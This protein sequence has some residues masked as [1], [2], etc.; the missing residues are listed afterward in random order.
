MNKHPTCGSPPRSCYILDRGCNTSVSLIDQ[1]RHLLKTRIDVVR[2]KENHKDNLKL[3]LEDIKSATK[4]FSQDNIIGHGDSGNVYKGATHNT[5][6]DNIIAAK[7]LDK[8][9][10]QGDAEILTEVAAAKFMAELDILME[11]K[12]INV[13]GLVGYCDEEDENVVVY[14]YASR[15][16]LDKYLSDDSLTWVMRLKICI[17]IALGLE[18][19][20][21]SVSSSGQ[22]GN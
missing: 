9:S 21:G 13:I 8:K 6:G 19:L 5:Q 20:H 14:E 16:S 15:G 12:H 11:Y 17:D 4:D 22:T 2:S 7:R 18:F 10:G 1:L 3:S